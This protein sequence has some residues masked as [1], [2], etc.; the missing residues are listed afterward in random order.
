MTVDRNVLIWLVCGGS[1]LFAFGLTSL[2]SGWKPRLPTFDLWAAL[3]DAAATEPEQPV[4]SDW[5]PD[6]G[7]P[8]DVFAY[9]AAIQRATDGRCDPE[10]VIAA[11]N[12]KLS[13]VEAATEYIR[14]ISEEG[15]APAEADAAEKKAVR[16]PRGAT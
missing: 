16:R 10:F 13:P 5:P 3:R 4:G 14:Q 11:A 9:I 6:K 12:K 7:P 15:D 1:I 2:L 8:Q